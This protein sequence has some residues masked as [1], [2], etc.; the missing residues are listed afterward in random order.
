MFRTC[1]LLLIYLTF[2]ELSLISSA[3]VALDNVMKRQAIQDMKTVVVETEGPEVGIA[4][5]I[6]DSNSNFAMT[7]SKL[8]IYIR[9]YIRGISADKKYCHSCLLV[10]DY[11]YYAVVTIEE[12]YEEWI[13]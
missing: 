4:T 11:I 5:E 3:G 1:S 6:F 10:Y 13:F 2:S 12:L 8:E 7:R 9:G